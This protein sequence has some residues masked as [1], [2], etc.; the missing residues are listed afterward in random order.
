MP[1]VPA[2]CCSPPLSLAVTRCHPVSLAVP[3]PRSWDS[4]ASLPAGAGGS[5]GL[6]WGAELL[7]GTLLGWLCSAPELSWQSSLWADE[8]C[9]V[10]GKASC[11]LSPLGALGLMVWMFLFVGVFF[12][13]RSLYLPNLLNNFSFER[14]TGCS[15]TP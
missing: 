11:G 14:V 7:L 1:A 15:C 6:P 9:R 2:G 8:R 4:P 12:P 13:F 10:A 5:A 3:Q